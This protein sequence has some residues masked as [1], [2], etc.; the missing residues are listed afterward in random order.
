MIDTPWLTVKEAAEYARCS[1]REIYRLIHDKKIH[2]KKIVRRRLI[3]KQH[4]HDQIEKS[5]PVLGVQPEIHP[6]TRESH[7]LRLELPSS[8]R[9]VKKV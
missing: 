8:L 1:E 7:V 4:L 3:N 6:H 2:A 5:F 9:P